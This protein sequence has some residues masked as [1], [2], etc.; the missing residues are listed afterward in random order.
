MN[1]LFRIIGWLEALSFLGLVGIAMPLKHLYS[2]PHAT[3]IP[4]MV[5]GILFMGYIIL[6]GQMAQKEEWPR[7]KLWKAYFAS[8]FPMGTVVFDYKYFRKA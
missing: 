1:Q 3:Q 5:H 2:M 8:V 4:G 7:K 6:A